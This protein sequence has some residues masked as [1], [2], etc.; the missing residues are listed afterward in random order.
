MENRFAEGLEKLAACLTKPRSCKS[1]GK[2]MAR[3]GRLRE[4]YPTIAQFYDIQVEHR[5]GQVS[6]SH[7]KLPSPSNS[8]TGSQEDII[9]EPAARTWTTP[10]SG[11]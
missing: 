7:S 8:R 6:P 2:I 5:D 4:C 3:L 9:S 1:Y 11:L 10:K